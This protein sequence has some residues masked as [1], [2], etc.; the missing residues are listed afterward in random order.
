MAH[1]EIKFLLDILLDEC[2]LGLLSLGLE[3]REMS[4]M[5][6]GSCHGISDLSHS[7]HYQ[8][9]IDV[10]VLRNAIPIQCRILE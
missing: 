3:V 9:D 1:P 5:G 7:H 8:M 10:A 6:S 2:N 4:Y